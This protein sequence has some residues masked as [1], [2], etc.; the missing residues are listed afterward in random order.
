MPAP[1]L[2][3][4]QG[5]GIML[6]LA[7]ST[8]LQ[9]LFTPTMTIP[10]RFS[11]SIKVFF[12]SVA[13]LAA[14]A[15]DSLPGAAV[16][17]ALLPGVAV[18]GDSLPGAAVAGTLLPGAAVAGASLPGAAIAGAL[19]PSAAAQEATPAARAGPT[20][21]AL[22]FW[23]TT[24]EH[25]HKV[26][27]EIL[28]PL[29]DRYGEEL[30]IFFVEV[31]SVAGY[32]LWRK[33]WDVYGIGE[34]R[35]GVPL[36]VI[37]NAALLGEV[38]IAKDAPTAIDRG[39]AAGGLP[40]PASLGV[41]RANAEAHHQ[42][43]AALLTATPPLPDRTAASTLAPPD[44]G[45]PV[46]GPATGATEVGTASASGGVTATQGLTTSRAS[47]ATAAARPALAR[48]LAWL[49][50]VGLLLTAAYGLLVPGRAYLRPRLRP[51]WMPPANLDWL[52]PLVAILGIAV[53]AYL[54][55]KEVTG[56]ATFCPVGACDAVQSSKYARLP[57]PYP[58]V[59]HDSASGS[60]GFGL[61][62]SGLPVAALG[63]V[64]YILILGLWLWWKY[65]RGPT[66]PHALEALYGLTLIGVLFSIYLTALELFV[67]KEVCMW[68]LMSAVAV[69]LLLW[70]ALPSL[71]HRLAAV[72][73][74]SA[75][76]PRAS[77]PFAATTSPRRT[78]RAAGM[79]RAT[80]S[81]NSDRSQRSPAAKA[82]K[83]RKGRR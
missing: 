69:A 15:G 40:I 34:D 52:L 66:K 27:E 45:T 51:W 63:L 82:T 68:C 71:V 18:A 67:L 46:T 75:R 32:D 77:R 9:G 33:V 62:R 50:F 10:S 4:S 6:E 11:F 21:E 35:R 14:V 43:S 3:R 28:P 54:T 73:L 78:G 79:Q 59:V 42:L 24:C 17:G 83:R 80:V 8:F 29:Q 25:C 48:A 7:V 26:I 1:Q 81:A 2:T 47:T 19:L 56:T 16:A 31:Q 53:A 70:L 23:S 22:L 64:T 61:A 41:D 58:R 30:R 57:I 37:G 12:L 39:L 13:A 36:L 5:S 44:S 55:D 49:V 72:Q 60:I 38:E 74:R 76:G 20:V 65:R